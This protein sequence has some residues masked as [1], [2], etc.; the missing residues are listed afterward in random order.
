MSDCFFVLTGGP[1]AGK[2]TLLRHLAELG[3]RVAP[4]SART[5]IR[6]CGGRPEP[7]RFCEL[8]WEQ[9]LAGYE[10]ACGLTFFDR[11]LVDAW[12]TF[13]TYGLAPSAA[14]DA[15]LR[16]FR[17]APRAFIAPPWKAIYVHDAERD[18]TW[19]QAIAA[20][21][22]CAEAYLSWGYELTELPLARVE[23]RAAF[24]L[25]AIA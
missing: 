6:T 5:V 4:E 11:G 22:A 25:Q 18:Q 21:E 12:A 10:A 1:G 9:D 2:T 24:V 23:D 20:Y 19:P 8:I 15:A 16:R 7:R 3:Y 14:E 17:Y 13:Q